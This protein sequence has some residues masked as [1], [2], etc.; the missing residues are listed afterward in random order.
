M[1][2][3]RVGSAAAVEKLVDQP[4]RLFRAEGPATFN[5]RYCNKRVGSAAE[6]G[7]LAAPLPP[8]FGRPPGLPG[9]DAAGR[10]RRPDDGRSKWA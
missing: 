8:G 7:A 10:R 4:D 9:P 2:I 6:D 5:N 1:I 3:G